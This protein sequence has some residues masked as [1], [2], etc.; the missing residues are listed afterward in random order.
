MVHDL[1][2]WPDMIMEVD[3]EGD[4]VGEDM[5][6]EDMVADTVVEALEE[7]LEAFGGEHFSNLRCELKAFLSGER[8]L[9]L[10][11]AT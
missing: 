10:T 3:I 4:M 7:A 6:A 8:K 1:P 9:N 5:V 11:K 2:R